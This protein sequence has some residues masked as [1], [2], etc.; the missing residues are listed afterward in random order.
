VTSRAV[1]AAI[2]SCICLGW[3]PAQTPAAQTSP[4]PFFIANGTGARGFL[5]G[6]RQ[7]A[8]WA[9]DA[10]AR[11]AP[12][13]HFEPSRENDALVRLYW[14]EANDGLYGEMKPLSVAG[15]RGGAVFIQPDVSLL[16]EAISSRARQDALFRDTVVYLTCLHEIGHA[17]GLTHTADFRDIMYFFGFGGDIVD[18]FNRYRIQL[19]SRTDIARVSGLSAADARRLAAALQ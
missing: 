10:W 11:A 2:A 14:T 7:L 12:G 1:T 18:Y 17:L 3:A 9:L 8:L 16:G 13:L 15:R 6:D 19:G 4:V 5:S